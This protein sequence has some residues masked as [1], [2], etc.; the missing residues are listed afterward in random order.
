MVLRT[1]TP[2]S[3]VNCES[4]PPMIDQSKMCIEDHDIWEIAEAGKNLWIVILDL[5]CEDEEFDCSFRMIYRIFVSMICEM[6]WMKRGILHPDSPLSDKESI[7]QSVWLSSK[8]HIL[9]ALS[10]ILSE[11]TWIPT[12]HSHNRRFQDAQNFNFY[13][14]Y[15]IFLEECRTYIYNTLR[16][17][18]VSTPGSPQG[19][20]PSPLVW[21]SLRRDTSWRSGKHER[22]SAGS[23]LRYRVFDLPANA[24]FFF[25]LQWA[26]WSYFLISFLLNEGILR[27]VRQNIHNWQT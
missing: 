5:G 14:Y 4:H 10:L 16:L 2:D 12:I 3:S 19:D 11:F 18:V 27:W 13:L 9:S 24:H 1:L 22:I 15:H 23:C 21:P 26:M 6:R 8:L 17:C 25:I 20:V 7:P